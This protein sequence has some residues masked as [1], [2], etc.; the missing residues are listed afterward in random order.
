MKT[1]HAAPGIALFVRRKL[2]EQQIAYE[3]QQT[4]ELAGRRFIGLHLPDL[5]SR[6]T[7][8]APPPDMATTLGQG[9]GCKGGNTNR[10]EI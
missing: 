3:L 1:D 9:D 2:E 6:V 4:T 7:T 10:N 8:S 5:K